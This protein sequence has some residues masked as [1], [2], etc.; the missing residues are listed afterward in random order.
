MSTATRR[1]SPR[2]R[3]AIARLNQRYGPAP[4]GDALPAAASPAA[5]GTTA[6]A[7]WI[8]WERKRGKLHELNRLLRGATDTTFMADRSGSRAVP[9]GVRYVVTLDADTRLPRDAVRRLIGKMAHPLNRPRF[10]ADAGAASSRAMRILQPRVTPSLPIGR[11]GSLFQRIFS[12]A[13]GIDP[14]ASAVS[15]VYQDLFGEGSYTGKGIY[16]VDAFEAA[17]AGRAPDDA[18]SATICSKASSRAPASPPTSRWSRNFPRATTSAPLRQHRWARG[19]W[20]LLPWIF[21]RGPSQA[22]TA[23]ASTAFRRSAAGRCWTICAARCRRPPRSWP[24]S[25]A[26]PLPLRR[27]ARLDAVR[28]PDDR[29]CRRS[30]RSSAADPA[31]PPGHHAARAIC[32]RSATICGLALTLSALTVTFLA[33]Q[34]WLMGDAIGRTLWRLLRHPPPSARMGH[35]RA[36]DDRSAARP[37]RL[38]SRAWPA[39]SSSPRSA[40]LV[41]LASRPRHRGRWRCPSPRCGSPRRGRALGEPAAAACAGRPLCRRRRASA[42]ADRAPHLALLRDLRHAGRQHAAAGQFPGRSDAGASPIG[43]RRPISASIC[44]RSSQRP[45]FRLDRDA[46]EAIER[47]EAT[48]AT[49]SRLAR[50][51]GHFFNWYDTRD[52]RPLDPRYVSSVDS[53]NLAG[54]LIALAN[55]CG[56]GGSSASTPRR[57]C[58]ASPTRSTHPR[59]RRPP[60]R[61]PPDADRDPGISSTTALAVAGISVAAGVAVAG[62]SLATARGL[63]RQGRDHGRHRPRARDRTRRRRRARICCSGRAPS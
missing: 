11:E 62:R 63:A 31:A 28:R 34:A 58:A 12:G 6:K 60:A 42:A 39:R 21:G 59:R 51:R 61:R 32:A 8:G 4:G 13:S 30:F 15:D 37:H 23:S 36:G 38:L 43:P 47:L 48:L 20:Q 9:T 19:D 10:D 26:G 18:C 14:Y 27:R 57:A 49:L 52:L 17:L 55:A 40:M 29:A 16:D 7:Q 2:R 46:V 50:F 56:S 3:K 45:R 53:G 54:H 41:A 33:H 35:R 5:S 44:S 1:C 25:R 22:G 24:C